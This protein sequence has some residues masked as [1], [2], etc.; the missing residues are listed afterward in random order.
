MTAPDQRHGR[1]RAEQTAR[2]ECRVQVTHTGL[3]GLG[4][5]PH[6]LSDTLLT[7]LY[8]IADRWK[9]R[10]DLEARRWEPRGP[11]GEGTH[12]VALGAVL[13]TASASARA[14]ACTR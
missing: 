13:L 8:A 12:E 14:A 3:V 4:L 10:A 1:G 11:A 2:T 7:S 5:E 6:L 9:G